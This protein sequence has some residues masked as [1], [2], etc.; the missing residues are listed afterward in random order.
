MQTFLKASILAVAF[1]PSLVF[2]QANWF[3]AEGEQEFTLNGSG[4]SDNDFDTNTFDMSASWGQYLTPR[5]LVGV[6][7]FLSVIDQ[8]NSG[9][10]LD[11]STAVFYD[12]HFDFNR[13]RP[14][15][16][17]NLG[18]NYGDRSEETFSAGPEAGLKYYVRTKTFIQA[19][20]Q[21]QFLFEDADEADDNF[22]DGIFSY[23]LGVGYNF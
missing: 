7:Q 13:A 10:D 3:P 1:T 16:G 18:Y 17:V 2:A 23:S 21:Y 6:R 12:H 9:T 5:G 15:I 14:F 20:V 4:K 22:E 19:M 8:E 11:G